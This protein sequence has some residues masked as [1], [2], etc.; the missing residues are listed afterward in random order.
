MTYFVVAWLF[1][2]RMFL[3]VKPLVNKIEIMSNYLQ[4]TFYANIRVRACPLTVY[5]GD[6]NADGSVTLKDIPFFVDILVSG[7]STCQSDVNKDGVTDLQD[8]GPFVDLLTGG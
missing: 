1:N 3:S 7:T 8:V 6:F 5:V 2:D 4:F